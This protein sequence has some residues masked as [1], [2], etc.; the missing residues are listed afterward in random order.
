MKHNAFPVDA[1]ILK[2][3]Y[4]HD[5]SYIEYELSYPR[6]HMHAIGVN[7]NDKAQIINKL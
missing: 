6:F 4:I 2:I 3:H 7:I 1:N 5:N